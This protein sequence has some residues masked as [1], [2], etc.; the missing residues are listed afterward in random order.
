MSKV[1]CVLVLPETKALL[2]QQETTFTVMDYTPEKLPRDFML[3]I[4]TTKHKT[5]FEVMD[6]FYYFT[7]SN[8]HIVHS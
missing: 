4:L 6:M 5:I 3:S 1:F 7:I 8:H 2:M